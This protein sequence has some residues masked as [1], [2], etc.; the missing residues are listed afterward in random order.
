[1]INLSMMVY[2][3]Q[4][5]NYPSYGF[6]Y[7]ND[8][9]DSY[10]LLGHGDQLFN[11]G[12]L[13]YLDQLHPYG[14]LRDYD[15]LVH[16]GLLF[17]NGLNQMIYAQKIKENYTGEPTW[18]PLCLFRKLRLVVSALEPL[19]ECLQFIAVGDSLLS[20]FWSEIPVSFLLFHTICNRGLD[21]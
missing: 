12:L 16:N 2:Y 4:K 21:R 17:V 20:W 13:C 5:I 19:L 18:A 7:L 1:M 6:L 9:L 10:G 11:F 14:L 8:Q 3:P 15:Q